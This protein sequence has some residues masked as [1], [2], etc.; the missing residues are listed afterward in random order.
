MKTIIRILF[1]VCVAIL[2]VACTPSETPPTSEIYNLVD[3]TGSHQSQPV[4][5]TADKLMRL[6]GLDSE[7]KSGVTYTQS[8]ITEVHLN[9]ELPIA[10]V[11]ASPSKYNKYKRRAKV[12][13]F[14]AQVMQAIEDVQQ[15]DY[16]RESST[17]FLNVNNTITKVANNNADQ[18][19]VIIQSDML[20]NSR[21]FSAY[22]RQD[23]KKLVQSPNYLAEL[24][25]Q[26]APITATSLSLQ[27][28]KVIIVFQPTDT[29]TDYAFR[30]ISQRFKDYLLSKGMQSVEVVANL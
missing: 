21:E 4:H 20:N 14:V 19:L 22:N 10:L 30:L 11:P 13:R 27:K 1:V 23:M 12:K 9:Q 29:Q 5:L 7:P 28:M 18:Q 17:I 2:F 16:D 3:V 8:L 24:L 25:E 26:Y 15:A 6:S